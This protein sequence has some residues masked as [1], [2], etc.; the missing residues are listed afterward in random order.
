MKFMFGLSI[1]SHA[2][3]KQPFRT[4]A[5]KWEVN[6]LLKKSS[7]FLSSCVCLCASVFTIIES[8]WYGKWVYNFTRLLVHTSLFVF[9]TYVTFHY[10][11]MCLFSLFVFT[12]YI[13]FYFL[14]LSLFFCFLVLT[15][16]FFFFYSSHFSLPGI[17]FLLLSR[18]F[19][20]FFFIS[21]FTF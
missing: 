17:L 3:L 4:L 2:T 6:M 20:C 11:V 8:L 19:L 9:F 16:L 5:I 21:L 15:P 18:T 10:L 1:L 12:T 7:C 13:T 14:A